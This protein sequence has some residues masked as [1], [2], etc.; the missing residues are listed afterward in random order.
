MLHSLTAR[1]P[2]KT[3]QLTTTAA[4]PNSPAE[5]LENIPAQTLA[6]ASG[7]L[8]T[9]PASPIMTPAVNAAYTLAHWANPGDGDI[10]AL[11]VGL[12]A[13]G[14]ALRKGDLT[15]AERMLMAHASTLDV[16]FHQ[17]ARRAAQ[18][19]DHSIGAC[20]A[21]LRLALKAQSQCRA[22]LEALS[23]VKSPRSVS[24]VRQANIANGPQQVNNRISPPSP[25]RRK[26]KSAERTIEE[27]RHVQL[28]P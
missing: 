20:D 21:Y 12:A 4:H 10:D 7:D 26:R 1:E 18:T 16:I 8:P 22:T 19:A 17:L 9:A 15:D 11:I 6:I 24:F 27:S 14:Q 2:M 3:T 23:W 28:D 5:S 13:Q 25:H